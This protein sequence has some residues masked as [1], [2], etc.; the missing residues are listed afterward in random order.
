MNR[1]FVTVLLLS[2]SAWSSQRWTMDAPSATVACRM[3]EREALESG[4]DDV[5]ADEAVHA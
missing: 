4:F 1:Y 3:A 2:G 5:I